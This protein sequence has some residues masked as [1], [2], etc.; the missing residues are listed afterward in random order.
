[1]LEVTIRKVFP[2]QDETTEVVSF[3]TDKSCQEFLEVV[4]EE[5]VRKACE[6]SGI[7]FSKEFVKGLFSTKTSSEAHFLTNKQHS[8]RKNQVYSFN[9]KIDKL[10]QN[11]EYILKIQIKTT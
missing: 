7:K 8:S 9:K 10:S 6:K 11:F 4:Q 2:T 1:M 3:D 5:R